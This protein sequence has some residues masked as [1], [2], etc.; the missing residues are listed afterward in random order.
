VPSNPVATNPAPAGTDLTTVADELYG[1]LPAQFTAARDARAAEARRAGDKQ[2]AGEIKALKKP[3]TGAWLANLLVRERRAQVDRLVDL[4]AELRQA[5]AGLAA[6]EVRRLSQE[7]HRVVASLRDEARVLARDVGQPVSDAVALELEGTLDAALADAD[8]AAALRSGQLTAGLHYSGLGL[9]DV[10]PTA[11]PPAT[12]T[13]PVA[14]QT[15]PEPPAESRRGGARQT[16]PEPRIE[17]EKALRMAETTVGQAEQDAQE[18]RHRVDALRG[19]VDRA[20]HQV[21]ELESQLRELRAAEDK[22]KQELR[23]AEKTRDDRDGKLREA[24]D[25]LARTRATLEALA[26]PA[27]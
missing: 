3:T 14:A 2:L 21:I 25:Q 7:R 27:T 12:G 5:Q 16:R 19:E 10:A 15:L 4:G 24:H 6:D 22:A 1:L 23:K 18:Q 13:P 11:G 17:A 8:A 9:A 26:P 20:H